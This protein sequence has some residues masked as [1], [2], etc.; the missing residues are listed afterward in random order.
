MAQAKLLAEARIHNQGLVDVNHLME[1]AAE[2]HNLDDSARKAMNEAAEIP[3]VRSIVQALEAGNFPMNQSDSNIDDTPPKSEVEHT[4]VKQSE[5]DSTS[6]TSEME[7]T[8]PKTE[9]V[10]TPV[11]HEAADDSPN[12]K[13]EPEAA[14]DSPKKSEVQDDEPPAES[15]PPKDADGT[16]QL[17]QAPMNEPVAVV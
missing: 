12:N 14:D 3:V 15:E 10:E 4:P 13:S 11:E 2:F 7:D 8:P 6:A 5:V 1:E 17:E 9:T 16:D